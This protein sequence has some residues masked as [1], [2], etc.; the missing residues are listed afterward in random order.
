M[1]HKYHI[2]H[3]LARGSD[4]KTYCTM[5]EIILQWLRSRSG[6][7]MTSH[8][9]PVTRDRRPGPG[10]SESVSSRL[11]V[12]AAA[13]PRPGLRL[14]AS[15]PAVRVTSH[16]SVSRIGSRPALAGRPARRGRGPRSR[17]RGPGRPVP[18]RRRSAWLAAGFHR[19]SAREPR[20]TVTSL[21][22]RVT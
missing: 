3:I 16:T 22:A 2:D 8:G 20:P 18:P 10:G 11:P 13:V 9:H 1:L 7:Q 6:L 21:T 14:P 5:L 12:M 4:I 19:I 15:T 17:P